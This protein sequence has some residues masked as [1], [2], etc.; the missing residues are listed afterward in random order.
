MSW[1]HDL[2]INE[3]KPALER[4]SGGGTGST[5]SVNI[6]K[7]LAT[8]IPIVIGKSDLNGVTEIANSAFLST[9]IESLDLPSSVHTIGRYAFKSSKLSSLI[10]PE[11]VESLLNSAFYQST[12]SSVKL[13]KTLKYIDNFVFSECSNLVGTFEFPDSVDY[14]GGQI[15]ARSPVE[16]IKVYCSAANYAANAF[17]KIT[18]LKSV[19]VL[20]GKENA[21]FSKAL[22]AF[23]D[24]PAL[25]DVSL[26]EGI[27]TIPNYCFYNC[28]GLKTLTLP[29]TVTELNAGC[30]YG[31]KNMETINIPGR[32][33]K[34]DSNNFGGCVS[35][36]NVSIAQ[37]KFKGNASSFRF[38]EC[39]E[40]TVESLLNILNALEDNT[41]ETLT[42]TLYLG[43]TNLAKLTEDQMAIAYDKNINLA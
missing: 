38:S 34:N 4:H 15:L 28:T 16:H 5:E 29:S 9:P 32:I 10:L 20:S 3:A 37:F 24:S 35:L 31:C 36:K 11:G 23:A 39:S 8:G 43:S 13:P 22:Y 30:F 17:A 6:I 19:E 41:N 12:I 1:L 18:T 14:Y 40:L 26:S 2:F 27:V 7:Q 25:V 42:Y 33:S 21:S